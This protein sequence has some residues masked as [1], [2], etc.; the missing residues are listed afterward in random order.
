MC[1][2]D[3]HFAIRLSEGELLC[4]TFQGR[5]N[6]IF[7]LLGNDH[8]QMNAFFVPDAT[9]HDCWAPLELLSSV[10][11]RRQPHSG[12]QLLIKWSGLEGESNLMQRPSS[13]FEVPSNHTLVFRWSSSI[14]SSLSL[15][16]LQRTAI[17]ISI[18]AQHWNTIRMIYR[19]RW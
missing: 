2:S 5:H 15:L 18:L 12:S 8:L 7:N 10:T 13:I 16:D 6:S 14:P 9:D 19:S 4:Y 3:P 11:V 1:G 17:L